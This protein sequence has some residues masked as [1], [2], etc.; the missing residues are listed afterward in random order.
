M[1]LPDALAVEMAGTA[2]AQVCAEFERPLAMLRTVSERTVSDR[3]DDTAHADF[4]R[5]IAEPWLR[6]G[7]AAVL[8]ALSG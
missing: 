3:A 4:T 6:Q 2:A 1:S 5:F 8:A 7:G